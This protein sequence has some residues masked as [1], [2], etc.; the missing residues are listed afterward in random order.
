MR[1]TNTKI[2]CTIN[3]NINYSTKI[4][5]SGKTKILIALKTK[6]IKCVQQTQKY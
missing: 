3:K 6:N 1:S 5:A 4:I 2:L